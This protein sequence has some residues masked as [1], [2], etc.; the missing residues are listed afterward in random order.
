[1]REVSHGLAG[2]LERSRSG[3]LPRS[4]GPSAVFVPF[5]SPVPLPSRVRRSSL[6][7]LGECGS[8]CAAMG[9]RRAWARRFVSN[10]HP[11]RPLPA[12]AARPVCSP[13]TRAGSSSAS[14]T[15]SSRMGSSPRA[16]VSLGSGE[17]V[18]SGR[19]AQGRGDGA[20]PVCV[21]RVAEHGQDVSEAEGRGV[22]GRGRF[23]VV[24]APSVAGLSK[25]MLRRGRALERSGVH[26]R[27]ALGPWHAEA[28]S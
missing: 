4:A 3:A 5:E 10:R 6:F 19:E 22:S 11:M 16:P 14:S 8:A 17:G 15:A 26:L 27:M 12:L 28:R 25:G 2:P 1:M 9:L 24:G 7:S 13:E 23:R 21:G 20:G 18:G